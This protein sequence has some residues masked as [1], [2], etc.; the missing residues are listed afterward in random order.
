MSNLANLAWACQGCNS[1]KYDK[2]EAVDPVTT[3]IVPLFH[4]R[5]D[6]W[7]QHFVWSGDYRL[8]VGLTAIGRAT[9]AALQMNRRPLVNLRGVLVAAGEHPPAHHR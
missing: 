4:P 3:R 8:I 2:V 9:V 6:D 7:Q 1:H 5:V